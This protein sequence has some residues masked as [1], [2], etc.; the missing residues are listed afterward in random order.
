MS[1]SQLLLPATV[2]ARRN[3]S[4]NSQEGEHDG[5]QSESASN[6]KALQESAGMR[7]SVIIDKHE[8]EKHARAKSPF[9]GLLASRVSCVDCGY[10]VCERSSSFAFRM[11]SSDLAMIV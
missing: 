4:G 2:N 7:E 3:S 6:E 10:T 5:G 1:T 11:T 8:Q 9:M